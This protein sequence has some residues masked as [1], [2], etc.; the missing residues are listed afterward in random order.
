MTSRISPK[1]RPVILCGGAGTRLWPVSRQTYPKQ[2]LP[3]TGDRS[4]LQQTADRLSGNL[5][6]PAIVVSGEDQRFLVERQLAG[7]AVEAILLEPAGRN[8][9]AAAALAAAWLD[10]S[11]RDE[12]ILL[13]PSDHV[14]GNR[15]AFIQAIEIAVPHAEHGAIVT[16]GASPSEPNTQ[17]GYIEADA[18]GSFGDGAFPI[19]RF[20]E[21]PNA[22]KATEYLAAG[23][24]YWNAGIFLAKAGT[25]LREM[26]SF[27]PLS[28]D[29]VTAAVEGASNEGLFVRPSADAFNRAENIS[30][31]HA[32]MEKTT[33]GVVVP[34]QMD[35]SD[36]GSWDAVWK[37]GAADEHGNVTTGSVVAIDTRDSLLRSDADLMIA[38]VGLDRMAVIA[39]RDAVFVAP[40]ERV[41]EVKNIVEVLKGQEPERIASPTKTAC[42]WGSSET[43][44][45]GP[46]FHV[47]RITVDPG[48]S[49]SLEE[50]FQCSGQWIVISGSAEA[51]VGGD[52]SILQENESIHIP[53]GTVHRLANSAEVPLELVAL[54]W[55]PC[56]DKNSTKRFQDR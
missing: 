1:I 9:A 29:A 42:P 48:R 10:A 56:E 50:H 43:I 34:V 30:I 39:V 45:N 51:T 38:A 13:M 32:I 33:R 3:V 55:G 14:I 19:K 53:A 20:V 11:G 16:F 22:E 12:L 49:F 18:S 28:L 17:Y 24:F 41:A 7:T 54:L 23:R 5:F 36:V 37:L 21:K 40:L 8:T 26:R 25:I 6:G 4:L 27:L 44:A 47:K 35:W 15:D 31:D 52:I 46:N 2:F